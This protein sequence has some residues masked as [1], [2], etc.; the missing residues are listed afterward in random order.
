M[1]SIY[2]TSVPQHHTPGI[3][4]PGHQNTEEAACHASSLLFLSLSD[5]CCNGHGLC[6]MCISSL[7]H[8]NYCED[9]VSEMFQI[10]GK[11]ERVRKIEMDT[12]RE[13]H[14]K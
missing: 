2:N 1:V 11:T 6:V 8:D 12:E 3:I 5:W 14:R 10:L 4:T 9:M 13:T 7:T